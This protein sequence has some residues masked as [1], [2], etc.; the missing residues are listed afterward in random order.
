VPTDT[1]LMDSAAIAPFLES[2]YPH[3][4]VVLH[5]ELGGEVER[6][7]KSASAVQA[8]GV[9]LMPREVNVL[10]PRAQE[11][12]RRTRE[13]S[14]GKKLEDLL[15]DPPGNEERAWAA[16]ADDMRAASELMQTNKDEGPFVLGARP[17]WIDY[18]IAGNLQCARVV[19]EPAFERIVA[20]PGYRQIYEACQPWM[21][22]KD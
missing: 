9:S 5:S 21:E 17:S 13:A 12:F 6:K 3:P 11:F 1:F 18:F 14:I 7:A 19:H 16:A 10:P 4:P 2:T 15:S 20:Y 8:F 22:K